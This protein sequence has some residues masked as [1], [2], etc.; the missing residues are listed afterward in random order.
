LIEEK[1]DLKGKLLELD[2]KLKRK[3]RKPTIKLESNARGKLI[4]KRPKRMPLL[5]NRRKTVRHR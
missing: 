5:S 1:G 2:K 3:P 4:V